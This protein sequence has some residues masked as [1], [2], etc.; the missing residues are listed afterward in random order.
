MTS[1]AGQS[2]RPR[3]SR[4]ALIVTGVVVLVLFL[5]ALATTIISTRVSGTSMTP[6]LRNGERFLISPGS[7]GSA[8][9]FDVVVAHEP[10]AVGRTEIVKRVIAVPGDA[11]EIGSTAGMVQLRLG[12]RGPWYR[13]VAQTWGARWAIASPC[14]TRD[15]RR[16]TAP[17]AQVV[18]AGQYFVLG[19]NPDES[20]DSRA[21]GWVSA[22][23][24]TGRV[25]IVVWPPGQFGGVG[26]RPRLEPVLR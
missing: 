19:D 13:V 10:G 2:Q 21:F 14:C 20:T 7:D 12:N 22:R 3:S 17:T 1:P 25:G 6:T 11:I 15:G 16:S 9:R 5:G 8:H 18:P 24:I 23:E 4:I 26:N